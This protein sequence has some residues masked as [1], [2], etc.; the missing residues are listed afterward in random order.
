MAHTAHHTPVLPPHPDTNL[1]R[2]CTQCLGW[3]TVVTRDGDHE[4]CHT[5]QPDP[6]GREDS[7][8]FTR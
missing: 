6:G 2:D 5:C 4:L 8:R 7:S 3:G 1:A